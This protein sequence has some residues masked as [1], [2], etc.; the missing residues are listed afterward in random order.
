[1][2]PL[3]VLLVIFLLTAISTKIIRQKWMLAFAGKLAMSVMLLFTAIGHFLFP[4]GMAMMIPEFIPNEKELIYL[5]GVIEI[6]AAI[7]LLFPRSQRLTAWLL[8]L[9]FIMILPANIYA[10]IH[11]V[12]IKMANY[13]G[14]GVNYLWFRIPL[15]L[16]FI[17]WVYY[18]GIKKARIQ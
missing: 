14:Q 17:V 7:G 2:E 11:H 18:F 8:I 1:M 6:A 4:E 10:A 15:Q 12:N 3:V 16:F 13:D 9:F 5:T